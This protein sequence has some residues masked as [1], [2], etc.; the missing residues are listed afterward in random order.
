M[1]TLSSHKANHPQKC[2]LVDLDGQTSA[3]FLADVDEQL[4]SALSILDLLLDC[5][6]GRT[7]ALDKA[8]VHSPQGYDLVKA[9]TSL[10]RAGQLLFQPDVNTTVYL[11]QV[12]QPL[13]SQYDFIILD[14]PPANGIV[15]QNALCAA[16]Q[17]LVPC[18]R[19]SAS[20]SG[21][22]DV[23]ALQH[24]LTQQGLSHAAMNGAV[25][26]NATTRSKDSKANLAEM[27]Q[28][29]DARVFRYPTLRSMDIVP[30]CIND[31]VPVIERAKGDNYKALATFANDFYHRT[32]ELQAKEL[33]GSDAS[34]IA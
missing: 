17:I 27:E 28:A 32:K 23:L 10:D 33:Q 7:V 20:L 22:D 30:D 13:K 19:T 3:T 11:T 8:I 14:C 6:M 18:D 12:L 1:S 5:S 26:T 9:A 24:G 2:L 16:D 21:L 4:D 25:I 31:C 29:I 15:V 34:E